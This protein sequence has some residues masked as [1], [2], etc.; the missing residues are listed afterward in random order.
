MNLNKVFII[1]NLT[2]DPEVRTTPNGH[3]V[4][5]FG[6]ATNRYWKDQNGQKQSEVE[7]HNVVVWGN[8]AK[9]AKDY[10]SKG[11][12]ALI[13]GRIK[14]RTWE[15]QNG[16][17]RMRTEIIGERLQLGPF[18]GDSPD[19]QQTDDLDNEK[20]EE[21]PT[22]DSDEINSVDDLPF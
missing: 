4:A 20:A 13:E 11:K 3:S 12:L 10:L 18:K 6:V 17:K 21:L 14:T 9:V 1:G 8:L 15:D 7:F 19:K 2:R 16:Q 5:Q 22:V